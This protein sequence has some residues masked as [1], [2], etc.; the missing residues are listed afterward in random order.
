[1]KIKLTQL[2]ENT[3]KIIGVAVLDYAKTIRRIDKEASKKYMLLG[4]RLIH[5][6]LIV[7]EYQYTEQEKGGQDEAGH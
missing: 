2:D 1:M 7:G 4:T 5:G 3:R 6:E